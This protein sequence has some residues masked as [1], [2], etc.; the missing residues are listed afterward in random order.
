MTQ[1]R[2]WEKALERYR[3]DGPL[4]GA[5]P[6]SDAFASGWDAHIDYKVDQHE[7]QMEQGSGCAVPLFFIGGLV[8][9]MPLFAVTM[10]VLFNPGASINFTNVALTIVGGAAL[11]VLGRVRLRKE[12]ADYREAKRAFDGKWGRL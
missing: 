6:V 12:R 5:D 8:V 11:L 7:L 4:P 10:L 1:Q 3:A 2:A 9:I